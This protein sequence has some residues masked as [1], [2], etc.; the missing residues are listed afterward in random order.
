MKK[1]E[2]GV[3]E[4][5]GKLE[6][7]FGDLLSQEDVPPRKMTK[8]NCLHWDS[9]MQLNIVLAIEQEFGVRISDREAVDISSFAAAAELLHEKLGLKA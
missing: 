2:E 4:A 9:L 8:V 3:S 7:I 1:G 5:E 6:A